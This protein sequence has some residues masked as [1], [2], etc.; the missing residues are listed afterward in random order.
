MRAH[1]AAAPVVPLPAPVSVTEIW[2][3]ILRCWKTLPGALHSLGMDDTAEFGESQVRELCHRV[4]SDNSLRAE[5]ALSAL[6]C[7][8]SPRNSRVLR[9]SVLRLLGTCPSRQTFSEWSN[10]VFLQCENLAVLGPF[11]STGG[12]PARATAGSPKA[13]S[14]RPPQ[15]SERGAAG[16]GGASGTGGGNFGRLPISAS[17]FAEAMTL[18]E[19]HVEDAM[20]WFKALCEW[21][22]EV[23]DFVV[24]ARRMTSNPRILTERGTT[25]A[26]E[27]HHMPVEDVAVRLIC[28][29]GD[30]SNAF[31]FKSRQEQK[32][33]L[34][35]SL[36]GSNLLKPRNVVPNPLSPRVSGSASF[37]DPASLECNTYDA[38]VPMPKAAASPP[39]TPSSS[40][41]RLGGGGGGGVSVSVASAGSPRRCDV[42]A[43]LL[44]GSDMDSVFG[45]DTASEASTVR[46]TVAWTPPNAEQWTRALRGSP[47]CLLLSMGDARTE[48]MR[49]LAKHKPRSASALAALFPNLC[50]RLCVARLSFVTNELI[51]VRYC[52]AELGFYGEG[53]FWA[54]ETKP[55]FGQRPFLALAPSDA[56]EQA[57]ET[58]RS[59]V[60]SAQCALI[61]TQAI[62]G[63]ATMRA[64]SMADAGGEEWTLQIFAS[65]DGY[66]ADAPV[67]GKLRL[68]VVPRPAISC[69]P[70]RPEMV[71]T[72][73]HAKDASI[74]LTWSHPV[75][76]GG[77][78]VIS[79]EVG[80]WDAS[81]GQDIRA[82]LRVC[83]GS[84]VQQPF[85]VDGLTYA[86]EYVFRVR[87]ETK[88]GLSEWSTASLPFR[89]SPG[90]PNVVGMPEV[91]GAS[92]DRM[93][94]RWPTCAGDVSSYEVL[95]QPASG[96][97]W[98]IEIAPPPF[99]ADPLLTN[100][101]LTQA[102]I[103]GLEPNQVYRFSICAINSIGKGPMG[104]PSEPA[105]TAPG[106]PA[107]PGIARQV[108]AS[109]SEISLAWSAPP[110]DGGT[111]VIR[112]FLVGLECTQAAMKGG[113]L[114]PEPLEFDT[115]DASPS[116]TVEGLRAN[117][118]YVFRIY[119]LNSA[120]LSPPSPV[121]EVL[122]TGP[123]R[124]AAPT[125]LS[126]SDVEQ[127][128]VT[129]HWQPPVCNGGKA[130]RR[131]SVEVRFCADLPPL[132]TLS[133]LSVEA[134]IPGLR[135]NTQYIARVY[136][137]NGEGT[138]NPAELTFSTA[139]L[140]PSAPGQPRPMREPLAD[141]VMVEWGPPL[142]NG[143]SDI[144]QYTVQVD[145]CTRD[146]ELLQSGL[147]KFTVQFARCEVQGLR[148]GQCIRVSVSAWNAAGKGAM[149]EWS[150]V[151]PTIQPPPE[152]PP[153]PTVASA[154]SQTVVASWKAHAGGVLEHEVCIDE[155]LAEGSAPSAAFR[156]QRA[157][158]PP[159]VFRNLKVR[160]AYALRERVR[161]YGGWSEWSEDA[162]CT[163]S[164][165]WTK[166]EV[167]EHL[168]A[169]CGPSSSD[170]FR[171]FDT[172]CDG[173]LNLEDFVHGLDA[174]GLDAVPTEQKKRFF[175]EADR[176]QRGF[177][178]LSDFTHCFRPGP[179]L[180]RT[181][182]HGELKASDAA[183]EAKTPLMRRS[184][185]SKTLQRNPSS[186]NVLKRCATAR[187]SLRS[188]S[189]SVSPQRSLPPIWRS[190]PST[191]WSK[192]GARCAVPPPSCGASASRPVVG[193]RPYGPQG[194]LN[195]A[196]GAA[197]LGST[198][199]T[200]V[201]LRPHRRSPSPPC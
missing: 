27:G 84:H 90:L 78:P 106:A 36:S 100:T 79:Q 61:D 45:G 148:P 31:G 155:R 67:G 50:D 38:P 117:T 42:V 24:L 54:P 11:L 177:I 37:M 181:S 156:T 125:S 142:N 167:M 158:V 43:A 182:S 104:A 154:T 128:S 35:R 139:P 179:S 186:D 87:C 17:S 114:A 71:T 201:L 75:S 102:V 187:S 116:M 145:E 9:G 65:D 173:F 56:V 110:S 108:D 118:R 77:S 59:A 172:N 196:G 168:V 52:T 138:S 121:S 48:A 159:V 53:M 136:A 150:S 120:G 103:T 132:Q 146:G 189:R 162:E 137:E 70:G 113:D 3:R 93:T 176:A 123:E 10:R 190:P 127:D 99:P 171:S 112:Y 55:N 64:P 166:G 134:H 23:L 192:A 85:K 72:E 80:I 161:G 32:A 111:P 41:G 4:F 98:V 18:L 44:D 153:P 47:R 62:T 29:W 20:S 169:R 12:R 133:T 73:S 26:D 178:S 97:S 119:A 6:W 66:N 13:P 198:V 144:Q 115:P 152:R 140:P 195:T 88:A 193:Q 8:S 40:R 46:K 21:P 95:C 7:S 92:G 170:I 141:A 19:V 81:L 129:L 131:Y 58:P 1:G 57:I 69:I 197:A 147:Q 83:R 157:L 30:L 22:E 174:V 96:E 122:L 109:R 101:S 149:S 86:T 200:P 68:S 15:A 130:I 183:S 25:S 160:T 89:S 124:S 164:E 191:S 33:S 94:L 126:V 5:E 135:G 199:I 60:R 28:A 51:V 188:P 14:P 107:A 163:T 165:E 76:V 194:R 16:A 39:M 180:P 34:R 151:I 175:G 105:R 91:I 74:T 2:C 143:G 82:P 49:Q 63:V 184:W 185:S